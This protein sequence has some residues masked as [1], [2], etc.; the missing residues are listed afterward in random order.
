[1]PPRA[2]SHVEVF[3]AQAAFV[4]LLGSR[5]VQAGK[6]KFVHASGCLVQWDMHHMMN[7]TPS[8]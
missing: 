1:M 2:T 6:L 3:H 8:H 4:S 5:T 7:T